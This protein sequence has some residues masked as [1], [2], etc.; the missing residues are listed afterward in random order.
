MRTEKA[1]LQ[2]VVML[3]KEFARFENAVSFSLLDGYFLSVSPIARQV[4]KVYLSLGMKYEKMAASPN[5][6]FYYQFQYFLLPE[7]FAAKTIYGR[8]TGD[9]A[10]LLLSDKPG[11][12]AY[13]QDVLMPTVL[14]NKLL[15]ESIHLICFDRFFP[16]RKNYFFNKTWDS[17]TAKNWVLT[18]LSIES[19]VLAAELL[20]SLVEMN[21]LNLYTTRSSCHQRAEPPNDLKVVTDS[22]NELGLKTVFNV[23]V[24]G[25]LAAN[26]RPNDLNLFNNTGKEIM[27]ILSNPQDHGNLLTRATHLSPTFRRES[28]NRYFNSL[29]MLAHFPDTVENFPLLDALNSDV[30]KETAEFAFSTLI[31]PAFR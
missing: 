31:E 16:G 8:P 1:T 25:Y 15:H 11:Y 13:P 3:H 6:N 28:N 9:F 12:A 2:N 10:A 20:A 18:H 22:L 29:G 5:E 30:A 21:P 27:Q 23:L 26:L 7:E 19:C 24:R 4:R 17:Q 14:N